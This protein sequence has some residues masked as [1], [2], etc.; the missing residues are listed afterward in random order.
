MPRERG[1][2]LRPLLGLTRGDVLSYLAERGIPFR[3]DA[4]NSDDRYLR[5]RIRNR[6]IPF[7]DEFFPH[8]KRPVLFLAETQGLTADFLKAEAAKRV[9]WQG[10]GGIF[11]TPEEVFFSQPGI[12]REEALF[13]ILDYD[14]AKR[15]RTSFFPD[16]P[17]KGAA[18][19]RRASLRLFTGE[20]FP[21]MDLGPVRVIRKGN[22]VTV[23]SR[24]VPSRDG[25]YALLI[26]RPGIYRLKGLTA[27]VIFPALEADGLSETGEPG[28]E[29]FFALLPLVLRRSVQDDYILQA[30][31][32]K[33][34]PAIL[35]GE[36]SSRYTDIITAEDLKGAAAF[37]SINGKVLLRR[38]RGDAEFFLIRTRFHTPPLSG[39]R[40]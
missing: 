25:G 29:F 34:L 4:T 31:R 36:G 23:I 11:S 26:K 13:R 21:A 22:R 18:V 5:N 16:F 35:D 1:R 10:Q 14:K 38:E 20:K 37:I 6:L 2:I 12:I 19:P 28:G 17:V 8:W 7:L 33:H 15:R 39:A 40:T 32:K 24:K 30:G 9:S 27:E 3:T